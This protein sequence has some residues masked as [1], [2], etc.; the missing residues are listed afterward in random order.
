MLEAAGEIRG[1]P[2]EFLIDRLDRIAQLAFVSALEGSYR[3]EIRLAPRGVPQLDEGEV[4]EDGPERSCDVIA[5]GAEPRPQDRSAQ[6]RLRDVFVDPRPPRVRIAAFG[7]QQEVEVLS[8]VIRE[9]SLGE[10]T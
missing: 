4:G 6:P 5:A 7:Q 2:T 8:E 3:L 1:S 10:R 9:R